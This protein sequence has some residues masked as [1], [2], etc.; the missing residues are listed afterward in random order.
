LFERESL[1]DKEA[2]SMFNLITA[3]TVLAALILG[4]EKPAAAYSEACGCACCTGDVPA[5]PVAAASA[6]AKRHFTYAHDYAPPDRS[7]ANPIEQQ[8]GE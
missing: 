8:V 3:A 7:M 5:P 2:L 1:Y 6:G 4:T